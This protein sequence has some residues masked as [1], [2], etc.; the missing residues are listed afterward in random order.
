[1]AEDKVFILI[2][3]IFLKSTIEVADCK[4]IKS[5][6]VE[7]LC[8]LNSGGGSTWCTAKAIDENP[9]NSS[10][11]NNLKTRVLLCKI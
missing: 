4:I 10:K 11:L 2:Q 1:M 9:V 3:L 5:N 8:L 6:N 7:C